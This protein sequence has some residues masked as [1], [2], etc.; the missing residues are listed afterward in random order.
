VTI[1]AKFANAKKVQKPCVRNEN[2][3][4]A[5]LCKPNNLAK[6]ATSGIEIHNLVAVTVSKDCPISAS[7]IIDSIPSALQKILK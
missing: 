5:M 6:V 1:L 2:L 3:A 4:P 7:Q